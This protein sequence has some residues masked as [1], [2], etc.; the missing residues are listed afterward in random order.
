V[1]KAVVF[2]VGGVLLDWNPRHLYKTM[3]DGDDEAM[4]RF[5]ADVCS[6]AWNLSLDAGKPFASGV[7]ELCERFPERTALIALYDSRWE[8][9]V[10]GAFEDTV[11]LARTLKANGVPLYALTNFSSEKMALVRTRYDFFMLFDGMVVSGE[12]G[13]VK[14]D[15]AI[16]RHL[17]ERFNLRADETLFIDD[18]TL[19]IAGAEAAGLNAI[20]FQSASGLRSEL[21]QWGLL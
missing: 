6:P 13:M 5:L 10:R 12:I 3:F 9:M 17:L 19:N 20:H 18:S 11:D 21:V 2:D 15:P 7:A 14:P 4:E 1:I 16:Y 8:D